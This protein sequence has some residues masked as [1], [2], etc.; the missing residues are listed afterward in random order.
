MARVCLFHWKSSEAEHLLKVL[1]AAGHQVMYESKMVHY[2][3]LRRDPPEA[4]VIDLT[5][6]PSH[7][8]EVA[9]FIR[10]SKHLHRVP[11]V[12][13][14]GDPEKVAAIHRLIPDATYTPASRIKSALRTALAHPPENPVRPQQMMERWAAHPTAKKLGITANARVAVIDPPPDYVRAI[15]DL[16]EG[17]SFEE[18]T[19]AEENPADCKLALWF[20]HGPAEFHAALP[21]MRRLAARSRLWILW[22]KSRQDGLN[23]NVIR[24][25][26][27][28]VGLVDY[29]VCSVNE[30]WSAMV[31]AV[32]KPAVKKSGVKQSK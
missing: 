2:A 15:G 32:K 22:R 29:K 10:G 7:G 6:A 13:I 4:I 25:G 23:G 11:I 31:F 19:H 5:R 3:D 8:R 16:P 30:T 28:A 14:D 9:V 26:A 20:V 17:A 27:I 12:F 1:R 18:V 24:E 21:A